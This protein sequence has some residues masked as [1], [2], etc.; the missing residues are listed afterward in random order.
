MA[1]LLV[2]IVALLCTGVQARW[3]LAQSLDSELDSLLC[4]PRNYP[5][6]IIDI[7]ESMDRGA[8]LLDGVWAESVPACVS[9]CCKARGCDLALFKNEGTSKTGKNCYY[10]RCG[11]LDNCVMVQHSSFT[12]ITFLKGNYLCR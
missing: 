3:S 1:Y 9:G 10:V 8:E 5:G 2:F 6:V 7:H 12:T 4:S 11:V